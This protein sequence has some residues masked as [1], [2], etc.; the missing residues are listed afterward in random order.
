MKPITDIGAP[1]EREGNLS[2]ERHRNVREPGY[3]SEAR[4][5]ERLGRGGGRIFK[6]K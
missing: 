4:I 1:G 3:S 5:E 6:P 2:E